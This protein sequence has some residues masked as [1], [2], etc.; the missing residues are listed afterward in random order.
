MRGGCKSQ[1]LQPP[2]THYCNECAMQALVPSPNR[3]SI[4][5]HLLNHL[6]K[7]HGKGRTTIF[8]IAY[9][10]RDDGHSKRD[11]PEGSIETLRPG[12]VFL[13]SALVHIS[14]YE[15]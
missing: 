15:P 5:S 1:T 3:Y 7:W 2:M 14:L 13:L 4:K 9:A 8:A 12:G 11:G 10:S 6:L